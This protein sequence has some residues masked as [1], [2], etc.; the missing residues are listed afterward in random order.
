MGRQRLLA[1]RGNRCSGVVA[2]LF[3]RVTIWPTSA[4]LSPAVVR[5]RFTQVVCRQLCGL[6]LIWLTRPTFVTVWATL[7]LCIRTVLPIPGPLS[8][9]NSRRSFL[10]SSF[11]LGKSLRDHLIC[12]AWIFLGSRPVSKRRVS[13]EGTPSSLHTWEVIYYLYLRQFSLCF[14]HLWR[15][16]GVKPVYCT[17][18]QWPSTLFTLLSRVSRLGLSLGM[19]IALL[20]SYIYSL[21]ISRTF[22][23]CY[24]EV[25]TDQFCDVDFLLA[26]LHCC[27]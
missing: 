21:H 3:V 15:L 9:F 27:L 4:C 23:F 7:G 6:N 1:G 11:M 12:N 14:S 24:E 10:S 19:L 18:F 20:Y 16:E 8:N 13:F 5:K 25:F 17:V 26:F 2:V 22:S